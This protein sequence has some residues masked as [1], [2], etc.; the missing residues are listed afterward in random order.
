MDITLKKALYEKKET[1]TNP[2]NN[3]IVYLFFLPIAFFVLGSTINFFVPEHEENKEVWITVVE[4]LAGLIIT[5]IAF[6]W[7]YLLT[8]KLFKISFSK[9][10]ENYILFSGL[11]V[12]FFCI[13]LI[14]QSKLIKKIRCLADTLWTPVEEECSTEEESEKEEE[15][16]APAKQAASPLSQKRET[17]LSEVIQ[18]Q[19]NMYSGEQENSHNPHNELMPKA[20]YFNN[21]QYMAEQKQQSNLAGSYEHFSTEGERQN[22]NNYI[23]NYHQQNSPYEPMYSQSSL[24]SNY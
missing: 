2:F 13:F 20:E 12:S 3:E 19:Y 24:G 11:I 9:L 10:P 14:T 8:S 6:V 23:F 16:E 4:V 1:S 7:F 17:P 21:F 22:R 5:F 15:K 18:N